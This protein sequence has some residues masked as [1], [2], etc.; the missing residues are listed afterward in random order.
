MKTHPPFAIVHIGSVRV[1]IAIVHYASP[2]RIKILE[3]AQKETTFGEEIFR[4]QRLSFSSIHELSQILMGFRQLVADYG[5]TEVYPIAT[6]VI[7][8]AENSLGILDLLRLRTGFSFHVADMAEE[9][10]YKFFALHHR[11][12][13]EKAPL[14]KKP[15]LLLDVN[16]GG[17]G[18]T[19]W[20]AGR[21]L[22]QMNVEGGRLSVLE[23]FTKRQR[24]ELTFPSAMRDYFHASLSP[25]WPHIEKSSIS[26]LVLSGFEARILA[27]L[28]VPERKELPVVIGREMLL[29]FVDSLV[30]LT[31]KK[32]MHK[33]G[34]SERRATLLLPTLLLYDEIV[35]TMPIASIYVYDITFVTGCAAWY[36]AGLYS[37][38]AVEAQSELQI[39]L[40]R[41]IAARYGASSEHDGRVEK[42][43][44]LLFDAL[45]DVHGLTPRA[46]LLLRMSAILHEVGK[47]VNLR[48]YPLHSWQIIEGTDIF[49]VSDAEKRCI[50]AISYYYSKDNPDRHSTHYESLPR[51]QKIL[52]DKCCAILRLADALDQGHSGKIKDVTAT[53][54]KEELLITCES[55]EDISLVRWTFERASQL[56]REIFGITPLLHRK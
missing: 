36:G 27:S 6:T 10:F 37:P 33:F 26:T 16:S 20:K 13:K 47:Y 15:L 40:A 31:V 22:F 42:Y 51:E 41:S 1:S 8:E 35:R 12:L 39:D 46:R 4:T 38:K 45:Q 53:L 34:L 3:Q 19:G 14:G 56:F 25:L 55:E 28:L 11:L 21:L 44:T 7:R 52:T 50:A 18:F 29:H 32:L 48:N 2:D 30:P 49:G 43:A 17:V 54:A 24:Q 9:I 5:V 23:R